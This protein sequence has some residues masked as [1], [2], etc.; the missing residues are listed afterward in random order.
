LKQIIDNLGSAINLPISMKLNDDRVVEFDA[1]NVAKV[2]GIGIH[3]SMPGI[4]WDGCTISVETGETSTIV[5]VG[6]ATPS[7]SIV[8]ASGDDIDAVIALADHSVT[9]VNITLRVADGASG[10]DTIIAPLVT[11]AINNT[12]SNYS[13]AGS[14]P[15]RVGAEVYQNDTGKEM[16]VAVTGDGDCAGFCMG[17][18]VQENTFDL[19]FE[20]NMTAYQNLVVLVPAGWYYGSDGVCMLWVEYR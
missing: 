15:E 16:M 7:L 11:Q 9:D 18:T 20:F 17:S 1:T 10:T 5:Y 19:D 2:S 12:L 6:G 13:V 3:F 4:R 14:L 8:V